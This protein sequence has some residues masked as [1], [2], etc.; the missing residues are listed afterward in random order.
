ML[1]AE[2]NHK[3]I[4]NNYNN[5]IINNNYNNKNNKIKIIIIIKINL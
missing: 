4:T 3:I 2:N 1:K 5:K